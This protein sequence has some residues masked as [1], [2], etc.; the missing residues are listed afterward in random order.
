MAVTDPTRDF[1]Q[2][3]E[4]IDTK[5]KW[6]EDKLY[7]SQALMNLKKQLTTADSIKQYTEK[8]YSQALKVY[9]EGKKLTSITSAGIPGILYGLE[10]SMQ[11]S[12][13]PADYIPSVGKKSEALQKLLNYEPGDELNGDQREVLR[14]IL[15]W[16][17]DPDPK[18]TLQ[19]TSA[20]YELLATQQY[21]LTYRK[22]LERQEMLRKLMLAKTLREM[23]N[24]MTAEL[25]EE[26]NIGM[27]EGDRMIALLKL[28]EIHKMANELELESVKKI[29]AEINS[30]MSDPDFQRKCINK[31]VNW[32]INTEFLNTKKYSRT[33]TK[34]SLA[35]WE[36]RNPKGYQHK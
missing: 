2:S 13:N 34:F 14:D 1:R 17:D 4:W 12:L 28:T 30:E 23:A 36:S 19:F 3:L 9:N 25:I 18:G 7:Y 22:E 10:V 32:K 6:V 11:K 8:T 24:K 21:M 27:N 16:S 31:A 33:N 35:E 15:K 5:A 20:G 26:D 29:E